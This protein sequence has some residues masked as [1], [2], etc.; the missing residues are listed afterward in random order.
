[1]WNDIKQ[2]SSIYTVDEK[3]VQSLDQFVTDDFQATS[4]LDGFL[5]RYAITTPE[6]QSGSCFMCLN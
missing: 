4:T 6:T 3:E 2:E 1:M 5:N